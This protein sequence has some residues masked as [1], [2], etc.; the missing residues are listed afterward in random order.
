LLAAVDGVEAV[1]DIQHDAACDMAEAVAI[2][3]NHRPPI[4]IRTRRS[5]RFSVC[6]TVDCEQTGVI[7]QSV[8]RKF[9]HRIAAQAALVVTGVPTGGDHQHSKADSL[10]QSML[11]PRRHPRIK[12]AAGQPFGDTEPLLDLWPN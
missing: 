5:S 4:S 12:D 3:A 2:M 9:E 10:V 8:D 7:G 11:D 6:E 1:V